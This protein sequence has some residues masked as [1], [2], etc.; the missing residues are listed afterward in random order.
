MANGNHWIPLLCNYKS[1]GI[2]Q[3]TLTMGFHRIKK[4]QVFLI[5]L[6]TWSIP[7]VHSDWLFGSVFMLLRYYKGAKAS[8]QNLFYN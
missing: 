2:I 6:G 1:F 4:K 7:Y 3:I 5:G 8:K